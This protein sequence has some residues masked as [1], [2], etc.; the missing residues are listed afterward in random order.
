VAEYVYEVPEDVSLSAAKQTALEKAKIR[1]IAETYGTVVSESNTVRMA[2]RNGISSVDFLSIGGSDVKGEWI[3]TIGQPEYQIDYNAGKLI[4][5]VKAKGKIRELTT[6][7]VDFQAKVLRN[8]TEDRF[9]SEM[10]NNGDDFYLSFTS[11]VAG[12]LAIY[13]VDVGN[14]ATCILPYQRQQDGIY[15]V[16]ANQRYVFFSERDA[17]SVE[18]PLVDSYNLTALYPIEQNQVYV[19]FSPQPFV[20]AADNGFEGQLRQLKGDDF[21]KWL[22]KCRKRDVNMTVKMIPITIKK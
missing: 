11:P 16:K 21:Q 13:L 14:D 19:V 4:V 8:G 3:E 5:A 7:T 12:Y 20:K 2:N 6:I 15:A 17:A 1:A 9:E 18:K 22:A 10:F